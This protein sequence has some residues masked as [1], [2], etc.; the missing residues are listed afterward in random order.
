MVKRNQELNRQAIDMFA[1]IQQK[2]A[3]GATPA[4]TPAATPDKGPTTP[5]AEVA[6]A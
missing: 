2:N 1:K 3:A 6:T 5:D 4:E